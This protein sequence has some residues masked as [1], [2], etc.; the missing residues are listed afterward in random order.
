MSKPRTRAA[1]SV[2]YVSSSQA[3]KGRAGQGATAGLLHYYCRDWTAK[4]DW[5]TALYSACKY[6]KTGA[7]VFALAALAGP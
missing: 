3:V 7:G 5:T 4:T 1:N 6:R 2:V